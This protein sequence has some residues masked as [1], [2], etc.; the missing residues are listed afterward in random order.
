MPIEY[1]SL[2][3]LRL[4]NNIIFYENI[5]GGSYTIY[6]SYAVK[7]GRSITTKLL[8]WPK[9]D[10]SLMIQRRALEGRS[11]LNGVVL[12]RSYLRRSKL[13]GYVLSIIQ[14]TSTSELPVSICSRGIGL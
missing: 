5:T 2:M 3:S 1:G 11:N 8:E 10:I 13:W 6:D 7:G 4:D 9:D 12:R 14:I